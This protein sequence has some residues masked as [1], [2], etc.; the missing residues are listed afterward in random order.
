MKNQERFTVPQHNMML[1]L[2]E[3]SEGL[4]IAVGAISYNYHVAI[5]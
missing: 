1:L 3:A 5:Y 4:Q 2:P